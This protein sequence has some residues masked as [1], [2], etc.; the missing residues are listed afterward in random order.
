MYNYLKFAST[1]LLVI[2]GI[3]FAIRGEY[4]MWVY[5]IIFTF[6][7]IGGD[8]ILGDE[9]SN[10]KLKSRKLLNF[11]LYINLPLIFFSRN[12]IYMDGW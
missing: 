6:F 7:I 10:P 2:F 11:F 9:T 3:Y 4:W 1:P 12:N 5:Q 8:L